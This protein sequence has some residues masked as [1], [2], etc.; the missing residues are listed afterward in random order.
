MYTVY[1]LRSQVTGRYYKG[2]TNNLSRRLREHNNQE[3]KSTSKEAPWELVF[4]V[5]VA[6]R[7]DAL[8]LEK[9]LKNITGIKKLEA[10]IEKYSSRGSGGPD[11][12]PGA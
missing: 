11:A 5:D 3:E 9:K 12:T 10:F 6:T 1:I 8:I 2:Q 4:S 7:S